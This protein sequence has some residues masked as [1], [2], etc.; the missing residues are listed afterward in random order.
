[1][2]RVQSFKI[3]KTYPQKITPI[4]ISNLLIE[5]FLLGLTTTVIQYNF[6]CGSN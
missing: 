5:T 3:E 4:Y 1:M 2:P 6:C